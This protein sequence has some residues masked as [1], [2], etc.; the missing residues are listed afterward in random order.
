METTG[1]L[2]PREIVQEAF[3]VLREKCQVV[4]GALQSWVEGGDADGAA[5]EAAS[6]DSQ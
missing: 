4:E 3:A 6:Q 2:K 1:A 5:S